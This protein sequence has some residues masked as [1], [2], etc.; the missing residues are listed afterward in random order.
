MKVFSLVLLTLLLATL[1]SASL[2]ISFRSPYSE[3][4]YRDMFVRKKIPAFLIRRYEET[5]PSC[6]RK[7]VRVELLKGKKVCVDPEQGWFQQYRRQK[8]LTS[9]SM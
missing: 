8:E 9:T 5:P 6:S 1:W 4:C 2:G 7:A 3:C